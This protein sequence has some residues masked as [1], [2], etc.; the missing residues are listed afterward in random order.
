MTN[1][2]LYNAMYPKHKGIVK[3]YNYAWAVMKIA[4]PVW[5]IAHRIVSGDAKY[6]IGEVVIPVGTTYR[7]RCCDSQDYSIDD[8]G[9]F[10]I[11]FT[12]RNDYFEPPTAVP[13][14]TCN[15]LRFL[16]A[17]MHYD[18]MNEGIRRKNAQRQSVVDA[19]ASLT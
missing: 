4:Q 16:V 6:K 7:G 14:I 11:K 3:Q 5:T 17:V 8:K 10:G 1:K 13:W 9:I 18:E 2:E 19:Y 15:E 12:R